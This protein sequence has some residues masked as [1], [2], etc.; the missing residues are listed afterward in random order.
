MQKNSKTRKPAK[1]RE[2][3]PEKSVMSTRSQAPLD[4]FRLQMKLGYLLSEKCEFDD[5]RESFSR[6]LT[7]A[8]EVGDLRATMEALAG[9][10]RLAGEDDDNETQVQRLEQELDRLMRRYPSEVPPMA[11]YCKGAVAR[12]HGEYLLAQRYFHRYLRAVKR[13]E[14]DPKKRDAA[15]AKGWCVLAAVFQ[16]RGHLVRAVRLAHALLGKFENREYKSINGT[17]YLILGWAAERE[18][19]FES[20]MRWYHRAHGAFLGERNWH[21]HLYVLLGYARVARL[22]RNYPVAYLHLDLVEKAARAPT[23][24]Q[25]RKKIAKERERLEQDAV[26]L[27]IDSRKGVVKTRELGKVSLRKQYVLMGILEALSQ[28]HSSREVGEGGLSKAQIIEKVWNEPYRPEAHDNKLYY[29]INRLRKLLEP[30]VR[31]PQY[32]L[33]WKEGYRL[34]PGLRVHWVTER[35]QGKIKGG[36]KHEH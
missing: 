3:G 30:D 11:W 24:G 14:S 33:N 1:L 35:L 13:Q 19:D 22:Q 27:L 9:L 5:A 18:H 20:A 4:D 36:E 17:L 31:Q 21:M 8:Q 25:F 28:A 16:D 29:N 2:S 15:L 23:M 26:D 6:G 34:A 12:H 10:L 7:L 32:L